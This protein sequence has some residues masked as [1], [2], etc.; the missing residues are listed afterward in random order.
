MADNAKYLQAQAFTLAGA[1]ITL[2][3]TSITL[4]SMLQ[5]DGITPVVMTNFGNKGFATIE[6]GNGTREEQIAF[7]G[8]TQNAN[9]TATL[10]G[11]VNVLFASPYTETSGTALSHPG[12]AVLVISNTSG[13][14]N[15]FANTQDDET[16]VGLWNF[17]NGA[18]TPTLGVS[19]VAPTTDLQVV[20]KKYVDDIAIAGSPLAT[21]SVDG[22]TKLSVVAVSPTD[23]IAV[24]DNDTRVPPVDTSTMTAGQV[25]A[26]EGSSGTPSSSNKYL[27]E[28]DKTG[29]NMPTGSITMFGV[30]SA[31]TG[32]VLCDGASYLHTDYPAL[33][34]AIGT[35]FGS[36]DG[37]HFN[38][39]DMR[40]R[41]PIG[42]GTGTGG[43]ASGTGLPVG[44]A[45]LTARALAAW[46]GEQTHTLV[47]SEMPAHDHTAS[48]YAV[49]DGVAPHN[50]TGNLYANG[51]A[52]ASGQPGSVPS[53]G[54]DGAHNNIQPVMTLSFII[55]T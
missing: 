22:I 20:P 48:G 52:A 39:P 10:T 4:T 11:V 44:G 14:Y 33:F 8:I 30:A 24:G 43:G 23:P 36:A 40:G 34:S 54:G 12:G 41:A 26:L 32:W 2:G 49:S 55:K 50:A 27:T 6:P 17:P 18:N 29:S 5:I 9:G 7:T 46:T 19:Y 38:V 47:I 1:G 45:A 16:V 37:T 53:Q 51:S 13:F 28:G 31:P 25:E 21:N 3:A 15:R 42:T 35:T